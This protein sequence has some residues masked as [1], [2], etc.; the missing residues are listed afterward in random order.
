MRKAFMRL[1]NEYKLRIIST[2]QSNVD[3]VMMECLRFLHSIP[4]DPDVSKRLEAAEKRLDMIE[5]SAD[6]TQRYKLIKDL[7]YS[8]LFRI[9][10]DIA[11]EDCHFGNHPAVPSLIGFWKKL[12]VNWQN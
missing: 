9:L 5:Q 10:E 7:L 2:N 12:S 1:G 8:D 11:P 4:L 3:K 6:P